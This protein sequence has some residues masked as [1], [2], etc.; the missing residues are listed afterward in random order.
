MR[1]IWMF[2]ALWI[3]FAGVLILYSEPSYFGSI[4]WSLIFSRPPYKSEFSCWCGECKY[5]FLGE[6]YE[7]VYEPWTI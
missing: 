3:L 6:D 5:V 1:A 4:I 2:I 7:C